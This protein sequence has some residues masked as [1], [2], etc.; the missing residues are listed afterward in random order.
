M[1]TNSVSFEYANDFRTILV[2]FRLT[3]V[4]STPMISVRFEYAYDIT[5]LVR[6][7][8]PY[9]ISSLT[10]SVRFEYAYD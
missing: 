3:Y 6:V 5:F 1:R 10:I 2:R 7:R 8:F 4:L 9:V